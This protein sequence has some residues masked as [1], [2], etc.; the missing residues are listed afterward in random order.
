M[1]MVPHQ[2]RA[3]GLWETIGVRVARRGVAIESG[4]VCWRASLS[5][6]GSA[7]EKG[8]WI[9][10]FVLARTRKTVLLRT[11]DVRQIRRTVS[12]DE[13]GTRDGEQQRA[14]YPIDRPLTSPLSNEST[15]LSWLLQSG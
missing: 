4:L 10:I 13:E 12:G 1:D 15:A 7:K 11:H 8:V 6:T 14:V 2:D 3:D 9:G 5:R